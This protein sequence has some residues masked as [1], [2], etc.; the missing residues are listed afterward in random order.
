MVELGLVTCCAVQAHSG[1]RRGLWPESW[2]KCRN[3][4]YVYRALVKQHLK[5]EWSYLRSP[6]CGCADVLYREV[7]QLLVSEFIKEVSPLLPNPCHFQDYDRSMFLLSLIPKDAQTGPCA[8]IGGGK[9]GENGA[10]ITD[11]NRHDHHIVH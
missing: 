10:F 6:L 7:R 2:S 3:H 8:C 9:F 5:Y 4:F 11:R 1:L